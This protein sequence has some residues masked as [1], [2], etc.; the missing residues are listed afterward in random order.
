MP[1]DHDAEIKRFV[2][3]ALADHTTLAMQRISVNVAQGVVTLDGLAEWEFQRDEA[4]RLARACA[5]VR[6]V[7]NLIKVRPGAC[8]AVVIEQCIARAF[9]RQAMLDASNVHVAVHDSTAVL[10]GGVPS[11]RHLHLAQSAASAVAGITS[12]ESH[13]TV[14]S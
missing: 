3:R 9:E 4:E 12:V 2:E 1:N 13:L 14:G 11:L 7:T 5:R 6:D 8:G 10:S